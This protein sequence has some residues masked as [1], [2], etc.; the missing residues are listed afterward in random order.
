MLILIAHR[1]DGVP[2]T[3]YLGVSRRWAGGAVDSS[4]RLVRSL[5]DV[6]PWQRMLFDGVVGKPAPCR[7]DRN[8]VC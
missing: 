8:W 7:V 4:D 3:I 2:S 1:S 6:A 5:G